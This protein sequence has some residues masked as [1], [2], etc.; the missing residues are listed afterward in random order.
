VHTAHGWQ[1]LDRRGQTPGLHVILPFRLETLAAFGLLM[2][3]TAIFLQ[4]E[5]RRRCRAGH[6][7]EPPEGG[8]APLP[9]LLAQPKGFQAELGVC[10]SADGLFTR[11]AEVADGFLFD[12]GD[13]DG[14]EIA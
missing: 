7:R 1:R 10:E 6:L 3:R 13:R 4:D 12:L 14:G 8:P 9:A 11:P 5:L 2:H